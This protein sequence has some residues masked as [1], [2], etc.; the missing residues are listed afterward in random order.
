[1]EILVILFGMV[2]GIAVAFCRSDIK[3]LQRPSI[4]IAV[5]S[6]FFGSAIFVYGFVLVATLAG[7]PLDLLGYDNKSGLLVYPT[8][9]GLASM[10]TLPASTIIVFIYQ[11][12]LAVAVF[13]RKLEAA[14]LKTVPSGK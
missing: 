11:R 2:I 8:M 6:S 13:R 3:H 1:M 12:K 4:W 7:G 5:L 10:I 14:G 9:I